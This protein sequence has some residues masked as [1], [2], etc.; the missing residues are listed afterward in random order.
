MRASWALCAAFV[1]YIAVDA[2]KYPLSMYMTDA[3][4]LRFQIIPIS[5]LIPAK[6]GLAWLLIPRLGA[7]GPLVASA[8]AVVLCQF[9]PYAL[10]VRAELA[11]RRADVATRSTATELVEDL[12]DPVGTDPAQG[13]TQPHPPSRPEKDET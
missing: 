2:A 7:A 11:R 4:G 13:P 10:Y 5:L 6:I 9:V 12:T 8:I 3:R 1:V